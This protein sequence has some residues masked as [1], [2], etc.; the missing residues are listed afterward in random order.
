MQF[1]LRQSLQSNRPLV[2]AVMV[3]LVVTFLRTPL[4][5]GTF[6]GLVV[7][8]ICSFFTGLSGGAGGG[9]TPDA[10]SDARFAWILVCGFALTISLGVLARLGVSRFLS[11]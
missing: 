8:V 3:S 4:L 7:A 2:G 9:Q 11:I 10:S 6:A 5:N 1:S